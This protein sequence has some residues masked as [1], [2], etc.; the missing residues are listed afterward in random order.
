MHGLAVLPPDRWMEVNLLQTL[1]RHYCDTLHI[2]HYP[3][4]MGQLGSPEWRQT[5]DELNRELLRVADSLRK[6][7]RL[8]LIFCV[9]YDD[10]LLV[11]T[12][13]RLRDLGAT[14]VNYHVDMVFQWYRV[15]KTAPYFDMMAVAQTANTDHLKPYC[16]DI[17][18]MP[19][20]ANPEF[21]CSAQARQGY[22]QHVSF[23][24]SFNPYRRAI[25]AACIQNGFTPVVYGRNWQGKDDTAYKFDWDL[26]KL[27]HDLRFYGWPRWQ[28][29]GVASLTEPLRRKLSR[30]HRIGPLVGADLRGP[31][32]DEAMPGIFRTSQVNLGLSDTGWHHEETI[33]RS[34]RLQC[35]LRDFE[36]P[37]SGGFY[38]VQETPDHQEYYDLG[39]EIETW[40]EPTELIDKLSF[41]SRNPEAAEKIRQ[42]GQRRAVA[43]HTWKHRF[44][45]LLERLAARRAGVDG[46]RTNT[47]AVA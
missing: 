35:R 15:I 18:W 23:V 19:M 17:H 41:Y 37:M 31:C 7:G 46:R 26:H 33:V 25:L 11:D 2:F 45:R 34:G 43:C 20:A 42:A 32:A 30:R 28:A 24:G 21:Y 12:A 13:K 38:L 29:E 27:A 40:S 16:Q 14:M 5:R 1:R 3:G 39:T 8:D 47:L 4:G 10:F 9:V 22:Q 44:D 36:V 6:A